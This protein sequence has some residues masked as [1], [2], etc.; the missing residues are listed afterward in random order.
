MK[1]VIYK[2]INLIN[3]KFYVGS[4]TNHSE[5]FRTHR[6]KLRSGT[7]HCA[8]LQAAWNKYGEDKFTFNVVEEIP[9]SESLQAAEDKWLIAH[10]GKEHCYNVGM[11]SGAPWRDTP[12]EQHPQFGVPKSEEQRQKIST[13]L[14][15]Y[16]A[17]APEN[18]PRYGKRHSEETIAKM[19][20]KKHVPKGAE[21]YRYGKIVSDEVRKKIGDTQR[22]IKKGSRVYTEDGLRRAQENMRRTVEAHP[23]VIKE[24]AEVFAKF[25]AAVQHQYDYTGAVYTGALQRITGIICPKHGVFSQYAAQIRKGRGCPNCGAEV[26]GANKK[27]EMLKNWADPEFRARMLAARIK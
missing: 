7:H 22:S 21:H 23:P 9:E 18:H 25:P 5:R 26:H 10:V 16:Y 24:F 6:N 11:R 14:K 2:I 1:H 19:I 4:S 12:K 13:T 8:H 15:E 17:K 3:G 20:A 27:V